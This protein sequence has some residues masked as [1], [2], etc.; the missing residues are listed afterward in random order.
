MFSCGFLDV[1]QLLTTD[2][3]KPDD[4][5]FNTVPGHIRTSN[6]YYPYFRN[7]VDAID[8]THVMTH[9]SADRV[10]PYI[11]RKNFATK[12]IITAYLF[13]LQFIYV[14]AGWE[15]TAHDSRIFNSVINDKNSNFPHH[16]PEQHYL[17]DSGYPPQ[18]G[19]YHLIVTLDIILLIFV[20]PQI[21]QN[22]P[23]KILI[24]IIHVYVWQLREHL[25]YER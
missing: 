22:Q 25:E 20:K 7:C 15:D 9:L 2:I 11:G 8:D 23:M 3:S 13:D 18:L 6:Q 17:V 19:Y 1:V 5:Q 4:P 21:N 24:S 16:S 10:I 14:M 12:N